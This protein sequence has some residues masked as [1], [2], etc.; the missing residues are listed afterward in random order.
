MTYRERLEHLK[1]RWRDAN[2]EGELARGLPT[3]LD[4][5]KLVEELLDNVEPVR[6]VSSDSG[7]SVKRT[8]MGSHRVGFNPLSSGG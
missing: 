5:F 4:T 2:Y 6:A 3:V 1:R 7:V 8:H